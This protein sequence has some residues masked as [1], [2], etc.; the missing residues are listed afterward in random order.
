MADE[1]NKQPRGGEDKPK[2]RSRSG[3]SKPKADTAK[4]GG[5]SQKKDDGAPKQ[6]ARTAD[7]RGDIRAIVR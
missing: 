3:A 1:K 7:P 2:P 6:G 4:S 5:R